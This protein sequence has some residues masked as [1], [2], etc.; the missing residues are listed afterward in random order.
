MAEGLLRASY[1]E[2]YEV[3]SA[4]T[5]PTEVDPRTIRAMGEA[6]VDITSHHSK[7]IDEFQKT[8]FDF[9]VTV[10]DHARETCSFLPQATRQLHKGF[11]NPL[12]FKGTE[13]EIM[14]AFRNLRD[15]IKAWVHHTF[16]EGNEKQ[17]K[18]N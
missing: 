5:R 4:G 3:Y 2:M 13:D 1:G 16:G 6:G 9:V 12:D 7:G 15:E 11:E 17:I 10:C 8:E 14:T 18:K